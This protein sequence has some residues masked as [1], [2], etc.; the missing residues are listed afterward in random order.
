M[1][2]HALGLRNAHGDRFSLLY[3]WH[4]VPG[5]IGDRHQIELA[6]FDEVA[7]RD[8]TF[9]SMTVEQLSQ[10]FTPDGQSR[11]WFNYLTGR[12]LKPAHRSLE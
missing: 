2:K 12:Y 3:Y 11:A 1:I 5:E 9:H 8:I 7:G 4:Y 10:R 6:L